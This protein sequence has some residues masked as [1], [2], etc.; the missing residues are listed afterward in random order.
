MAHPNVVHS[1]E[2]PAVEQSQG[3]FQY[4]ARRLSTTA[5]GTT[6]GVSMYEVPPGKTAF[7]RSE[8]RRVGKECA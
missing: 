3:G 7:P 1:D 6:L 4:T 5:R 2:L 8:E